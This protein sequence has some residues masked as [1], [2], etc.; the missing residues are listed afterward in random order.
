MEELSDDEK[1]QIEESGEDASE[2]IVTKEKTDT[3]N[4]QSGIH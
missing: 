2:D 3:L 1:K 4:E